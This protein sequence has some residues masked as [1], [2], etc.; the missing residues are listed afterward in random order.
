MPLVEVLAPRDVLAGRAPEEVLRAVNRAIAAALQA[1][2]P[3][4]AWSSW[5]FVDAAAVGFADA[6]PPA[7]VVV[8]VYARRTSEEW[9]AIVAAI[10]ATLDAEL[11]L[12]DRGMLVTTQPFRG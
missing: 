10:E 2:R 4:V 7:P 1:P 6:Q 3:D 8:H 11:R 12:G 5:R 9:E